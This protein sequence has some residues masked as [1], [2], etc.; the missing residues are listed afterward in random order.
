MFFNLKI[1]KNLAVIC[2]KILPLLK[3]SLK[4]KDYESRIDK[5]DIIHMLR[6]VEP[7][8]DKMGIVEDMELGCYTG[9]DRFVW[10]YPCYNIWDK[11]SEEELFDLYER[12]VKDAK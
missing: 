7:N 3:I 10:K 8:F 4:Q 12:L 9:M 11:Y 1:I 2:G 6:G 5:K